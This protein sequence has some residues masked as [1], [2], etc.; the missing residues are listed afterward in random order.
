MMINYLQGDVSWLHYPV[1]A[2]SL[3][4]THLTVN[5]LNKFQSDRNVEN[6]LND[7]EN[8]VYNGHN[9]FCSL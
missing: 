3:S 4:Y 8:D 2:T 9:Q 5:L 1:S 7:T 6:A